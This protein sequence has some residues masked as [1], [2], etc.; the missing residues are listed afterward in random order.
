MPAEVFAG[1]SLS[2]LGTQVHIAVCEDIV[3]MELLLRMYCLH[4]IDI[5]GASFSN[6]R[7]V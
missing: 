5:A 6:V 3:I 1:M 4:T 7:M 2:H